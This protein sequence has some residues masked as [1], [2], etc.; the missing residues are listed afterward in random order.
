MSRSGGQSEVRSPVFK[1]SSKLGTSFI[2]PLQDGPWL[3]SYVNPWRINVQT[4]SRPINEESTGPLLLCPRM[5]S[6]LC[7]PDTPVTWSE[8]NTDR[9]PSEIKLYLIKP[10]LSS[11][12]RR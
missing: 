2:D 12:P 10:S 3:S 5:M 11:A 6:V 1:S 4:E 9:W 8:Q 7:T